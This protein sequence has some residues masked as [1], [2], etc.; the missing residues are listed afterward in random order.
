MILTAEHAEWGP[1]DITRRD[2][3]CGQPW[4]AIYRVSP[5]APLT[6]KV[7]GWGIVAK[8]LLRHGTRFL[9]H[10]PGGPDCAL[11]AH[12][13]RTH[14]ALKTALAE[15][16]RTAG[17]TARLE[18][19]SA[20]A[21]GSPGAWVA[22]VLAVAPDNSRRVALEAQHS[23]KTAEEIQ[24]RTRAC[25]ADGI[26]RVWF[27]TS[28]GHGWI[29]H[30]PSFLVQPPTTSSETWTVTAGPAVPVTDTETGDTELHPGEPLSLA[31]VLQWVLNAD[32]LPHR[33]TALPGHDWCGWWPLAWL[34][35]DEIRNLGGEPTDFPELIPPRA[36][37]ARIVDDE[38]DPDS[39]PSIG[40]SQ[41]HTLRDQDR[42]EE[43]DEEEHLKH[44]PRRQGK[45]QS[46]PK[47]H[48]NWVA[49]M[50]AWGEQAGRIA[51]RR[52]LRDK[53]LLAERHAAC[54][55]PCGE[56]CMDHRTG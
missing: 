44:R 35:P 54:R 40:N 48:Y 14:I 49:A 22:D 18:E 52:S 24:D 16:V 25:W 12:E 3:G 55:E 6:C 53:I 4:D 45:Y 32:L 34:S 23:T 20:R 37:A 36:A 1:I 30:V 31:T 19:P 7:C 11:K 13:T 39:R 47:D 29:G 15:A 51:A 8:Q 43:W 10:K 2:L 42:Y 21:G 33:A 9:A 5:P 50:V 28:G 38:T 41:E 46:D 56:E 26:P 27:G 17:W